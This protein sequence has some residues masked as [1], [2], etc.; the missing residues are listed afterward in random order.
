MGQNFISRIKIYKKSLIKS[1]YVLGGTISLCL[2]IIGIVVPG[3]PTTPFLLLTAMLYAKSSRRLYLWLIHNRYL[4]PYILEYQR[5]KGLTKQHKIF[6]ILLMWTMILISVLLFIPVTII[7]IIVILA[8]FTG[9][10]VVGMV[11]PTA[12]IQRKKDEFKAECQIQT[13]NKEKL[14]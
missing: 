9:S 13:F 11:V 7:K 10:Y 5:N 3:L 4:G 6:I 8:G 12:I 1:L 2:G 14:Y